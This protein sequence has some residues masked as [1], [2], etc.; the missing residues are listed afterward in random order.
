MSDL[1]FGGGW[2]RG[3]SADGLDRGWLEHPAVIALMC[4]AMQVP[5][6]V[7]CLVAFSI[8]FLLTP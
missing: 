7:I 8:A 4:A 5:T 1:D 6:Q 2:D 3:E